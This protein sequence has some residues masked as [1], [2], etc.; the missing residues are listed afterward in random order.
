MEFASRALY[1]HRPSPSVRDSVVPP[2]GP[3]AVRID[4]ML[5][6]AV[7][8]PAIGV[9]VTDASPK[10][11]IP[12]L[13]E[14][15]HALTD[16]QELLVHEL[17]TLQ[18]QHRNDSDTVIDWALR[19]DS[20]HSEPRGLAE[21][22]PPVLLDAQTED[23]S[24]QPHAT[25][26]PEFRRANGSMEL[27]Y[28]RGRHAVTDGRALAELEEAIQTETNT[29]KAPQSQADFILPRRDTNRTPAHAL[30]SI[31]STADVH[32]ES[33]DASADRNYN[34]FDELDAKLTDVRNLNTVPREE[35]SS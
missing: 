34:F 13:T 20:V 25:E 24:T 19:T 22:R 26:N 21:S 10:G 32:T 27:R 29:P 5:Q 3:G 17:R 8:A 2:H 12:Q 23:R 7:R 15:L 1:S 9:S 30:R 4:A 33:A 18:G 11:L 6:K 28:A 31:E 35:T 16:S 14:L